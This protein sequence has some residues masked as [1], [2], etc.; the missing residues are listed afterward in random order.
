[1]R[2][3]V[4]Y[5]VWLCSYTPLYLHFISCPHK[6]INL[7]FT[8]FSNTHSESLWQAAC[9]LCLTSTAESVHWCHVSTLCA[10]FFSTCILSFISSV[11]LTSSCFKLI[12]HCKYQ[13]NTK[14][15]TLLAVPLAGYST[16]SS[17]IAIS[18]PEWIVRF[19]RALFVVNHVEKKKK[20]KL[21]KLLNYFFL[22]KGHFFHLLYYKETFLSSTLGCCWQMLVCQR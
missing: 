12:L 9:A 13:R 14:L 6:P 18:W 4:I 1:M 10:S 21:R 19:W 3:Q 20:K 15:L 5:F 22:F 2:T 16:F 17:G 8:I 11:S 7:S